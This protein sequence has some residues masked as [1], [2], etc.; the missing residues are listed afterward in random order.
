MCP[1]DVA[2]PDAGSEAVP[3]GIRPPDDLVDAVEGENGRDGTEDLLACDRHLVADIG[4]DG[5]RNEVSL[6]K[7][8]LC[9]PRAAGNQSRSLPR[10]RIEVSEYAVQL[11]RGHERPELSRRV[12]A[13]PHAKRSR[14]LG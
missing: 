4:E 12:D 13:R 3:R 1:T 14:K 10:R 2:R 11:T 8:P 5:G 6:R 7:G 9:E